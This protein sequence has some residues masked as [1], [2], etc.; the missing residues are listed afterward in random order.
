MMRIV[1]ILAWPSTAL[2]TYSHAVNVDEQTE[3][4]DAFPL[5]GDL[6]YWMLGVAVVLSIIL[7]YVCRKK[8]CRHTFH[9]R[10]ELLRGKT[11]V[12][13]VK[14]RLQETTER[15]GKG[16]QPVAP[17]PGAPPNSPL[18]DRHSHWRMAKSGATA[19]RAGHG[20]VR[21]HKR[22]H[23]IAVAPYEQEKDKP[24]CDPDTIELEDF[25]GP[26]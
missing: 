10:V 6:R 9:A 11:F 26:P 14:R 16:Y 23:R 22:H 19:Q 24:N 3:E 18:Q 20:R 1:L 13:K 4:N 7:S 2:A 17:A 5:K 15:K 21:R 25:T 8:C 12:K